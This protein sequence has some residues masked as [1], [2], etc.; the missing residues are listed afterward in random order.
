M[1]YT[2][3]NTDRKSVKQSTLVNYWKMIFKKTWKTNVDSDIDKIKTVQNYSYENLYIF[4]VI[5]K[6]KM[7]FA[8]PQSMYYTNPR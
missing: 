4:L 2:I 8:Y 1:G 3:R 6:I 7:E 5:S